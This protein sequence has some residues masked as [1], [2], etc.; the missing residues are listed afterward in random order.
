MNKQGGSIALLFLEVG[1]HRSNKTFNQG[2]LMQPIL[3]PGRLLTPGKRGPRKPCFFMGR[4]INC[5]PR[6]RRKSVNLHEM[7]LVGI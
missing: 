2:K 1:H 3:A 7:P 4:I 5:C 6:V